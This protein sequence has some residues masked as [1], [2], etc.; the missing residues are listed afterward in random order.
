MVHSMLGP[1]TTPLI[2]LSLKNPHLVFRLVQ[3]KKSRLGKLGLG[4][5]LLPMWWQQVVSA[6]V[7]LRKR[8]VIPLFLFFFLR[9]VSV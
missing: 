3:M 8:A 1:E 9:E 4:L 7:W 5:V 2:F 6:P